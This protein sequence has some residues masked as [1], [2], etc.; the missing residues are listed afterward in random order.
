M[1][2][3]WETRFTIAGPNAEVRREDEQDQRRG[4]PP[5]A[6]KVGAERVKH[7]R[8]DQEGPDDGHAALGH[9]RAR[10]QH[11]PAAALVERDPKPRQSRLKGRAQAGLQSRTSI[12]RLALTS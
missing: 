12:K 1:A 8:I 4:R 5:D 2:R 9:A 3:A 11:D 6:E 7:A 10:G